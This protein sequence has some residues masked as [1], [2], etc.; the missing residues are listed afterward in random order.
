MRAYDGTHV[1]EYGEMQE[2][3]IGGGESV[4]FL[5]HLRNRNG[6]GRVRTWRGMYINELRDR[7]LGIRS[8]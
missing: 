1:R 3:R 4:C 7:H 5:P 2:L 8:E 6:T